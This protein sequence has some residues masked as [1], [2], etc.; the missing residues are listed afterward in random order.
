METEISRSAAMEAAEGVP[1][2]Y[3]RSLIE[4]EQVLTSRSIS[5]NPSE[6]DLR[7]LEFADSLLDFTMFPTTSDVYHDF[8]ELV[9][10][11]P[12]SSV[13]TAPTSISGMSPY[14]AI[15]PDQLMQPVLGEPWLVAIEPYN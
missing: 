5:S 12:D 1:N 15:W 8:S 14:Q 11:S 13:M 2:R 4:R 6:Q 9:T 7:M 10:L 3:M